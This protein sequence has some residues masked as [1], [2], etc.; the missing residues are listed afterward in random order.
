MRKE[1]EWRDNDLYV[2]NCSAATFLGFTAALI[3]VS[4][5]YVTC[6]FAVPTSI[7]LVLDSHT[8]P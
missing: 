5:A 8:C 1:R 7:V 6:R 3:A 4:V 2:V